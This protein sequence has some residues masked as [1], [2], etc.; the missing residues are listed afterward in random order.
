[1]RRDGSVQTLENMAKAAD[2]ISTGDVISHKV[3]S[4]QNWKLLGDLGLHSTLLPCQTASNFMSWPKF[5]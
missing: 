1:M 3:R 4:G 5:P 2:H